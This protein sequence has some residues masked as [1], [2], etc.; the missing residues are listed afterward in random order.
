M[1]GLGCEVIFTHVGGDTSEDDLLFAGGLDGSFEFRI[2]PSIHL[3]LT[4]NES[5]LRVHLNKLQRERAIGT[6]TTLK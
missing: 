6:Y 5:G 1:T 3:T 4:V 2:I